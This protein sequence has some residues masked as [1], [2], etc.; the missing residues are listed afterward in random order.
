MLKLVVKD[1]TLS[2][3]IFMVI[4]VHCFAINLFFKDTP[5]FIYILVP[6]LIVYEF[7]KDSCAYDYK[8]NLDIMFNSLPVS[9]RDIVI[10]KYIESI[11]V[12]ILGLIITIIFTFGFRSV[13]V[14]GF[15]FIK[16]LIHL[17]FVDKL[18]TFQ[19]ITMSYLLSTILLIS[20]Y[21]P[22]Y[23]KFEYL[24]VR[25]IFNI[26]S[27]IISFIPILL[28][29]IIGDENTYKLINYL[30]KGSGVI[31]IVAVI[32]ILII[33]LYISVKMSVKFYQSRD[34]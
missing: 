5:S 22:I 20:I 2:K 31:V 26:A 16:N 23:F 3:G 13:G 34:L 18:M 33:M 19:S 29:K 8:Y 14:T 4:L 6:P 30:S 28:I 25:T 10:S 12:F 1:I 21:F 15:T 9:R 24:K 27:L 7:F 17:E 11:I 32:C